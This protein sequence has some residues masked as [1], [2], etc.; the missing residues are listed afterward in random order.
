M[1]VRVRVR[2]IVLPQNKKNRNQDRKAYHQTMHVLLDKFEYNTV[3]VLVCKSF[4][5]L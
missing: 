4:D 5:E 2:V 3:V 1:R